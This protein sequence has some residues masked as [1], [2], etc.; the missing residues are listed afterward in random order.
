[1]TMSLIVSSEKQECSISTKKKSNPACANRMA[2]PGLL[3]SEIMGPNTTR[4]SLRACF[5]LF[6]KIIAKTVLSGHGTGQ[7]N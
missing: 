7:L 4:P 5:I 6:L 1:M 3:I 2:I